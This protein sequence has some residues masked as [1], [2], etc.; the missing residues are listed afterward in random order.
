MSTKHQLND[1]LQEWPFTL[2]S[3]ENNKMMTESDEE[4]EEEISSISPFDLYSEP[5]TGISFVEESALDEKDE[6][7]NLRQKNKQLEKERKQLKMVINNFKKFL[8][9]KDQL[10][11]NSEQEKL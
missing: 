1:N 2:P 8:K 4:L 3:D 6:L 10:K 9:P 5:I 11:V 7:K